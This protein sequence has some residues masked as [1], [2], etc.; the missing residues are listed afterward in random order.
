MGCST[1]Y[2]RPRRQASRSVGVT[3][4]PLRAPRRRNP[5]QADAS[6]R[7][8]DTRAALD[9]TD[10]DGVPDRAALVASDHNAP[11][12]NISSISRATP[13]FAAKGPLWK[14]NWK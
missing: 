4:T 2:G 7:R 13:G 1:V 6:L 8:C 5:G 3:T 14:P 11:W 12:R 9:T 10:C